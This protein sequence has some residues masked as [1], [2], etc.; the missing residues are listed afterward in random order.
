MNMPAG[1]I[2]L[3]IMCLGNATYP[4]T[5]E[6]FR[7]LL[8]DTRAPIS[9]SCCRSRCSIVYYVTW[10]HTYGLVGATCRSSFRCKVWP[11]V[12]RQRWEAHVR[13][14]EINIG[15]HG[16]SV[17]LSRWSWNVSV[18]MSSPASVI[19]WPLQDCCD[20]GRTTSAA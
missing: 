16:V 15:G 13:T 2:S 9:I 20:R 8:K 4:A 1:W 19:R 5:G 11:G 7:V 14:S 18:L 6:T 10:I 3:S 17:V 12:F